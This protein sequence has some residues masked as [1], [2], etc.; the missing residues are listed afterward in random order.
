MRD[1][2]DELEAESIYI[3]REAYKKLDKLAM[4]WS[5]GKDSNT[6]LWLARKAF[7]GNIPF[8]IMHIDTNYKIPEMIKF[9]DEFVKKWQLNLII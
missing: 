6:M 7:Y 4:L 8:P 2:L 3:F 1:Y 5:I 9:R